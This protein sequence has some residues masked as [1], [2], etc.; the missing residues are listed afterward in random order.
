MQT[1]NGKAPAMT[2]TV[3]TVD[4]LPLGLSRLGL[5]STRPVLV[6]VGGASG[7]D[8]RVADRLLALFRDRLAP[9]LDQLGAV[10][11]DGGT[12]A[13][14]MALMGQARRAARARFPLLGVA[15]RGTVRLPGE[16]MGT[17]AA[18]EPNHSHQLLVP[19]ASWGD[20]IPWMNA[21]AMLL[22][23][24]HG[25]ATLVAA[26]GRITRLDVEASLEHG[27][28]TLVLAGSG[29]T[30]DAIAGAGAHSGTSGEHSHRLIQVVP[31]A[32]AWGGLVATLT[33]LL[34][35]GASIGCAVANEA[36]PDEERD[37]S[38]S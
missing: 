29:G 16:S 18:L 8:A 32:D 26:G 34:V 28:P 2:E 13:G 23:V 19:G 20:E 24:G 21:V 33:R 12:D 30:A 37:V 35:E 38:G 27:R 6:S 10:V 3:A 7:L 14:V 22:G 11:V 25:S 31:Q 15:A 36:R 1:P 9:L 5:G 17:G 4:Q